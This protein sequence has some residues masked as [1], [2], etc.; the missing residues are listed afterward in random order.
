MTTAHAP[1]TS[2]P[3]ATPNGAQTQHAETDRPIVYVN[4]KYVPKSQAMVSV[5]DHGLLYGD[6]VFEGIRV[7]KGRIFKSKQHMERLWRS[8]EAIRLTIPIT[9]DEMV[10]IQREC[11]RVNNIEDGYI[12][13]IVSRGFGSLGLNPFKC[14]VAGVICIADQIALYPP[15]MYQ[16]GM[17]VVIAERPRIPIACLDPR[18]KSLNYLNNIMAKV[19]AIDHGCLE[20]VMLN[21]EG[22]VS[23]CSGDN[24][25]IIKNGRMFTPP[26]T[27]GIL[28]GITRE[29]VMKTL[30]PACDVPVE[31]KLFK[32]D[33]L[34]AADEIFLTGSAAEMIAVTQIDT[35]KNTKVV[36]ESKI[37]T[38]EGPVTRKLREKFRSIV[39]SPNVP[40]E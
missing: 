5:Y 29:F 17:R 9:P 27:A 32:V 3:S 12:R 10:A 7:Y 36:K 22:Y 24:I 34:L 6:G 40:E 13:L 21:T 16:K 15:E 18:I 39:T 20:C 26:T 2:K 19:E 23:E 30:A 33:E 1:S 4:G 14:P 37:S 11:I 8:A 31:E 25:F 28:E 35:L 38:G